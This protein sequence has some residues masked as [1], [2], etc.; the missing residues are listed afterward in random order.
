MQEE[1]ENKPDEAKEDPGEADE[2]PTNSIDEAKGVVKELKEQNAEL[3]KNLERAEK[4]EAEAILAGRADAGAEKK[5][6]EI[7]DEDYAEKIMAGDVPK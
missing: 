1:E 5:K 6:V 3:A 2:E 4:M 7:S